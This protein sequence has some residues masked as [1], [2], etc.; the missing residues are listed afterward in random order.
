MKNKN[1]LCLQTQ[2]VK[3]MEILRDNNE[4]EIVGEKNEKVR[5]VWK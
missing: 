3:L 1:K 5:G 4:K 2:Q